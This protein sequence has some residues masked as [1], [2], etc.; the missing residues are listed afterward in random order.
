MCGDVFDH[1][2]LLSERSVA[3]VAS[4]RFLTSMDLQM[5]LEVEP[6]AVDE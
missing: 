5:L 2:G 4:E 6:F 1:M 3:N